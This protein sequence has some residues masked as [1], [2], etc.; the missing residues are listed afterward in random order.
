MESI[1]QIR[2]VCPLC[3]EQIKFSIDEQ[4]IRETQKLPV[5][6]TF[7]HCNRILIIYLDA[8]LQVRGIDPAFKVNSNNNDSKDAIDSLHLTE[9]VDRD[10]IYKKTIEERTLYRVNSHRDAIN[11]QASPDIFEKQL[12][13]LLYK[14]KELSLYELLQEALILERALNIKVNYNLIERILK[15]YV[16]QNLITKRLLEFREEF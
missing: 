12:L 14:H 11:R 9:V 15:K 2:T 7:E 1:K 10:F 13:N 3:G 4:L 16:D 6:V 8:H 5:A